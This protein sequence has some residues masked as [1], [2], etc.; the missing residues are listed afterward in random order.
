MF[1][2][3]L[4]KVRRPAWAGG[5]REGGDGQIIFTAAPA[6][7]DI[8][9]PYANNIMW[10]DENDIYPLEVCLLNEICSNR[11]ELFSRR[12]GEPFYCALDYE[13]WRAASTALLRLG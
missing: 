3:I 9:P 13:G 8:G 6:L 12:V 7:L 4:G 1:C 10:F 2:V 5:S 11:G